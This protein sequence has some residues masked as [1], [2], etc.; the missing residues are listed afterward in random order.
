MPHLAELSSIYLIP[1]YK[2]PAP[3]ELFLFHVELALLYLQPIRAEDLP[4]PLQF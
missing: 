1:A 4:L 3:T 2:H